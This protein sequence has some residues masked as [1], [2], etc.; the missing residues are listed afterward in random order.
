M[1]FS[2]KSIFFINKVF[3]LLYKGIIF[4]YNN[5]GKSIFKIMLDMDH[6]AN[7]LK[8]HSYLM[9]MTQSF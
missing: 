3:E 4:L 8:E 1:D 5:V 7:Q 6:M 9:K 2:V